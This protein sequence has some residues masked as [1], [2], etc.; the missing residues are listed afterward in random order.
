M[1]YARGGQT[2]ARG[3]H[4]TRDKL[5]CSPRKPQANNNFKKLSNVEEM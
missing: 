4:V 3:P 5:L 2:A 1:I